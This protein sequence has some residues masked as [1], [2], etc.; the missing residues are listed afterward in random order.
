VRGASSGRRKMEVMARWKTW[1]FGSLG[2][3]GTLLLVLYAASVV[4]FANTPLQLALLVFTAFAAGLGWLGLLVSWLTYRLEAGRVPRPDV[5]I[6]DGDSMLTEWKVQLQRYEP[7]ES[8]ESLVSEEREHQ[9]RRA[10][11][12]RASGNT[13][14]SAFYVNQPTNE[15]W[16][17][18]ANHVEA[19]LGEYEEYVKAIRWR[20]I[21]RSISRAL[22]LVFTNDRGGAPANGVLVRLHFPEGEGLRILEQEEVPDEIEKPGAPSP[23][24]PRSPMLDL[25]SFAGGIRPI[26]PMPYGP[27]PD[28]SPPSNVSRPSFGK[29]SIRVQYEIEEILHNVLEDNKEYPLIVVFEKSGRWV[30]PYE[31]HARNLQIPRKGKLVI[32]AAFDEEPSGLDLPADS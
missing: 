26:S 24:S 6:M 23:P 17:E 28:V 32:E 15:D 10:N 22:F 19:Y 27:L 11:A 12:A 16:Q 29:G 9:S 25:A 3:L 8:I 30:V 20:D 1:L 14:F 31:V 13:R 18:Y 7:A 2:T 4:R 21:F 5:R